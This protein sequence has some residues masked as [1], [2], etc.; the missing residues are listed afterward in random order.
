MVKA[1]YLDDSY[2]QTFT[3][4]I[5]KVEGENVWLNK[6]AFYPTSG[7]QPHDTG[8]INDCE[9]VEVKKQEGD[10]VHT[11][12]G[13][14]KQKQN[15]SCVINWER[16]YA[17]MRM[18]T[19]AHILSKIIFNATKALCSGNELGEEKSRM[20]F[21]EPI[22]KEQCLEFVEQANKIIAKDLPV[23]HQFMPKEKAMSIS[24]AFRLFGKSH[25]TL[26]VLRM[27]RIGDFDI[28]ADGGTH[29]RSTKEVGM[30]R[31]LKFENKG[32]KR[33]RV[34]WALEPN[35]SSC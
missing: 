15:V 6:T 23:T 18:H 19:S 14:L 35:S 4:Q 26:D 10:I 11:I 25:P 12:R 13:E 8:T 24:D 7:G 28:Q 31:L 17:L 27:V 34:Y 9:V 21:S 3:A 32:S 33:K 29:V 20:D 30:I 16:R 5:T 2:L 1:L 22:T